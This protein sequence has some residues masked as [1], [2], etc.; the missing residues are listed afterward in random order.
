M[1]LLLVNPNASPHITARL[2]AS[3]RTALRPGDRLTAVNADAHTGPAVVR[4]A[5]GLRQAEANALALAAAHAGGHDAI[6]LGISLDGAAPALRAA[7]PERPVVG[8]TEAA[9]CTAA[10]A[11]ERIGLLTLGADLLPLYHARVA[12][13]G[14]AGRV[15]AAEA[16]DLP[17]AFAAPA[18]PPAS[19][20]APLD[21]GVVVVL[22][23][24]VRRLHARG[25]QSV[26][27]AGAVLCGYAPVLGTAT[28]VLCLDGVACA[29]GQLRTLLAARDGGGA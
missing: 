21:A 7:H 5:A 8:M 26:V 15:V 12:A 3:A 29:V 10:L 23:D 11:G 27:L 14:L 24:A 4:D 18:T 28:G 25:A 6:V 9:L 16:P 19:D 2:A 20:P 13:I 17:A 22:A 1:R